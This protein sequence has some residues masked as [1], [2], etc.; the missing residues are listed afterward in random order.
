MIRLLKRLLSKKNIQKKD[1]VGRSK[2]NLLIE[3]DTFDKGGLQKVVLDSAVRF[4]KDIFEVTIVS[5][6]GGGHL[7]EMAKQQNIVVYEL[8]LIGKEK[9]YK[10]ILRERNI[11]LS[12]L[13]FSHFGYPLL[14]DLNIPNITF[15]HNVYAFLRNKAL[16]DFIDSDKYVDLYISVS[17]NCTKYAV[18]KLGI[19]ES[20]VIT[21][22]NG[23]II[24][25]HQKRQENAMP[26]K[27]N[28][29]G[30][31]ENDYVFLNPASYNLHKGHYVMIDAMKKIIKTRQDIKILCIGNIIYK[32]HYDELVSYLKRSGLDQY[33]ILP[34]YVTGI[35]T[36]YPIVDAFLMPSF[37]EGWSIAMNE[38]M[39]YKKPLLMTDTGGA[40]DVIENSDIGILI[41]NEYGDTINLY[42]ESLDDM[43]YNQ[44]EFKISQH[45]A[46][47]MIEFADN[48]EYW[49]NA[50]EKGY[51]KIIEKYN[52][53]NVVKQYE[54]IFIDLISKKGIK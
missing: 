50:G 26:L 8:P 37:I 41:E 48:K 11:N 38:A 43:A 46:N 1:N 25:E 9:A 52:F 13:H 45:L 19:K 28:D 31:L 35:E 12:N 29:L 23:L 24:D 30:L 40:C 44:R 51:T 32:P 47:A 5:I 33:I 34:G 53:D 54:D 15:I 39:F 2:I 20:K 21:I 18:S 7:A 4:N 36:I 17:N 3:L 6:N 16:Q 42:S 27:R 22:P 49:K 10:K 14:K